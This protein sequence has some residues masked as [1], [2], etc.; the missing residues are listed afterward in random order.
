MK[1]AKKLIYTN[2][3]GFLLCGLLFYTVRFIIL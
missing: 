1:K 3:F 2:I